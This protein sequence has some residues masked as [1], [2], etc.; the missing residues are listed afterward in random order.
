[1]PRTSGDLRQERSDHGGTS[2]PLG[3]RGCQLPGKIPL[4]TLYYFTVPWSQPLCFWLASSFRTFNQGR[5]LGPNPSRQASDQ[6]N[7]IWIQE[8]N[9]EANII[10]IVLCLQAS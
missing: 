7:L 9:G 10:T 4:F 3:W 2:N 8:E 6:V 5:R 1:M